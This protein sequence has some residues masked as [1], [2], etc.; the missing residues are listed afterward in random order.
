MSFFV[1]KIRMVQ[2]HIM[3]VLYFVDM[4]SSIARYFCYHKIDMFF[5]SLK[6]RYDINLVAARQHI[7]CVSTYR[8]CKTYRKSRTRFISTKKR[9][10]SLSKSVFFSGSPSLTRTNDNNELKPTLYASH[11]KRH[12]HSAGFCQ[13][14]GSLPLPPAAVALKPVIPLRGTRTSARTACAAAVNLVWMVLIKLKK[15]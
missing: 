12:S 3:D 9:Q 6:T 10:I 13:F 1:W 11:L 5:V 4:Q 7:E 14:S 8:V 2:M 15:H